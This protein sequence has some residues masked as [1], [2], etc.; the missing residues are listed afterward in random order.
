MTS[1]KVSE[2]EICYRNIIC[3]IAGVGEVSIQTAC[4]A[5]EAGVKVATVA[6]YIDVRPVWH[7]SILVNWA[8]IHAGGLYQVS[9]LTFKFSQGDP[10]S[11]LAGPTCADKHVERSGTFA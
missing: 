11:V 3:V 2:I 8:G 5:C 1:K 10:R 6:A 4:E 9:A 7:G